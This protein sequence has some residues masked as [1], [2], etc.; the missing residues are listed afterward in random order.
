MPRAA[1]AYDESCRTRNRF[2]SRST[3][4]LYLWNLRLTIEAASGARIMKLGKWIVG[5]FAATLALAAFGAQA[6][7]ARHMG[8][9]LPVPLM[10]VQYYEYHYYGNGSVPYHHAPRQE[11]WDP[12]RYSY[13][14]DIF[15]ERQAARERARDM[16]WERERVRRRIEADERAERRQ[17]LREDR[18]RRWRWEPSVSY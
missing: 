16:A 13:G 17:E 5:V 10:E 7:P 3:W 12:D 8:E 15:D 1:P 9:G 11:R 14:R 6:A 18:H 4:P 2:S